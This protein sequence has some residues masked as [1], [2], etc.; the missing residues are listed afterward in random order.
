MREILRTGAN[1]VYVLA[2]PLG[3]LLIPAIAD[4][5]RKVDIERGR[6]LV[7]PLPGLLPGED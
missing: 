3:E 5:V 7:R 2:G 1:D 6:L 4:V